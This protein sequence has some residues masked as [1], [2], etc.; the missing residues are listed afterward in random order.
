VLLSLWYHIRPELKTPV[1]LVA[2][3]A[4]VKAAGKEKDL[5]EL[6]RKMEALETWVL[7]VV[8]PNLQAKAGLDS[9]A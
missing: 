6:E 7:R 1:P 8:I 5:E 4:S 9:F 2:L 3:N